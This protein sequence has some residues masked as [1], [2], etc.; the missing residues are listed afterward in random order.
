MDLETLE[1]AN[2]LNATIGKI[3]AVQS[4]NALTGVK[5]S[6]SIL[7]SAGGVIVAESQLRGAVGDTAYNTIAAAALTSLNTSL[8]S[9]KTAAQ[10][11]LEDL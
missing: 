5:A 8:A 11:A 9:A 6:I 7:D 1:S 3:S 4:K 10:D 2:G